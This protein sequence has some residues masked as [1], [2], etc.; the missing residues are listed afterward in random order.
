ME[1]SEIHEINV[2]I[3]KKINSNEDVIRRKSSRI[4]KDILDIEVILPLKC[5]IVL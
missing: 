3:L 2:H 5:Q 1:M 4:R